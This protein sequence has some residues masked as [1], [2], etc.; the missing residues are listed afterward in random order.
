VLLAYELHADRQAV[1]SHQRDRQDRREQ[2]SGLR[3]RALE[4]RG[5]DE[6]VGCRPRLNGGQR[7]LQVPVEP[8]DA[9][10]CLWLSWHP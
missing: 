10:A 6:E 8:R 7:G 9:A 3:D 5:L 2:H 1:D 4:S